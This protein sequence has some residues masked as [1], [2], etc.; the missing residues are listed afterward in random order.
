MQKTNYYSNVSLYRNKNQSPNQKIS[1][2]WSIYLLIMKELQHIET[3]QPI[4][5]NVQRTQIIVK[6]YKWFQN[7]K[8]VQI[9]H[10]R[11][12]HKLKLLN[13]LV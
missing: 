11:N 12:K 3:N 6:K 2:T 1:C 5:L 8:T 9:P 13:L 4:F 10:K 7:I